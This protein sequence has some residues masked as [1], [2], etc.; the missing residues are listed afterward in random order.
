MIDKNDAPAGS[1][2]VEGIGDDSDCD[3]CM[4]YDL[5][6]GCTQYI[7]QPCVGM[8]R[9]DGSNVYFVD[10]DSHKNSTTKPLPEDPIAR[11]KV[12]VYSGL[13]KYF[14]NALAS[15]AHLS[16]MGNEQHNPGEP[17]HWDRSKSGDELDALVRHIIDGDWDAVARRALANLEKQIENGY[18]P[19]K[20]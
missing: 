15:V 17:L 6:G 13:I 9:K 16:Y 10:P 18:S 7:S 14:P 2:A 3:K 1:I 12:P 5:H 11:K 19:D 8:A 4:F 20:K